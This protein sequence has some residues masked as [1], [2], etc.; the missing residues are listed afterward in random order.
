MPHLQGAGTRTS[1]RSRRRSRLEPK[2]LGP[3]IGYTLAKYGMSLLALGWAAEFA[4]GRIASNALW[5]RTLIATAAVQNLL[6]GDAAMARRAQARGLRRR[7]LRGAQPRQPRVH[8]EHVPV[9]GRA[10]RGGRHRPR[11][12]TPTCRR[13]AP[14]RPLRR[15]RLGRTPMRWIALAALAAALTGCGAGGRTLHRADRLPPQG[16][17]SGRSGGRQAG[18]RGGRA[19]PTRRRAR[20]RSQVL[21]AAGRRRADAHRRS[22][23]G[24]GVRPAPGRVADLQV[25]RQDPGGL[26]RDEDHRRGR[27]RRPDRRRRARRDPHRRSRS[28]R[29]PAAWRRPAGSG[30]VDS[31]SSTRSRGSSAA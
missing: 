31:G 25:R 29:S 15:P 18:P 30:T 2:W 14:G 22:G 6:G 16:H 23:A 20:R 11:R 19:G 13:D 3:H 7:G 4:R 10:A 28:T 8:R 21:P 1:S 24:P 17:A 9:R 27:Q 12:T 5:P 26:R